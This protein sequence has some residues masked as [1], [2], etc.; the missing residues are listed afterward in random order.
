MNPDN[1]KRLKSLPTLT[2]RYI[3]GG[4]TITLLPPP[5]TYAA[6]TWAGRHNTARTQAGRAAIATRKAARST[7]YAKRLARRAQR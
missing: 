2:A 5:G 1:W 6:P 3:T 7:R 4:P